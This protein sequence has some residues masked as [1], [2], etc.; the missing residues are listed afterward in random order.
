MTPPE[1]F[2]TDLLASMSLAEK[3]GQ[4]TQGRIASYSKADAQTGLIDGRWGSRILAETGW[5]G[6]NENDALDV[7]EMNEQQRLAVEESLTGIPLLFGRDVIYGHRTVFPIPH[8]QA[9]SFNPGLVEKACTC[10]AR[11]AT[12]D[13]VKWTFAPMLDLVRDPRWGRV[14]ESY[15]EDPHLISEMGC[16]TVRG[17]QGDDPSAPDRM[18]AC[19]KHFAGYGGSEGGRDYHVTDWSDDTLHNM[20]LP[21]FRAAVEAGCA[22]VMSGFNQLGGQS[23]SASPRLTRDWLKDSL[24]WDGFIVSDWGSIN[25]LI[26]HGQAADRR[27]AAKLALEAGID[28]DMVDGLYE[29]ELAALVEDGSIPESLIDDAV[30]R[31][32]RAKQRAGLFERP[33]TEPNPAVQR[34]PDHVA[35]AEELAAQ[36]AVL[37][38]NDGI[39]PLDSGLKTVAVLGPYAEA[40]RQHL[41]SWCLDGRPAEV[42]PI[43]DALRRELPEITFRTANPAFS[44]EMM[45]VARNT[46]LTILCVGESHVRNGE[47]KSIS[48]LALPPGQEELIESF[49]R[50]GLNLVVVDCSGRHLPSPAA[51]RYARALLHA[52]SLGT[53]AGTAIAR[54]LSGAVSPSGKLP[55]TVPRS[56]GQIPLYYNAK[57]PGSAVHR[58]HFKGYEEQ[59]TSPLYPFG[60]GLTYSTFVLENTTLLSETLHAGE[61]VTLRTELRNT[62]ERTAAQVVQLYVQAAAANP[63]R[64]A[65]ELKAFQRI[66][67]AP[68]DSQVLEFTIGEKQLG[69]YT[70][71]GKWILRPGRFRLAIG[72]DSTSDFT[73]EVCYT[74]SPRTAGD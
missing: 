71:Q 13:G 26:H 20:I 62:G 5:A 66:E 67:L 10:V 49:G 19:A 53:E 48:E 51:E 70:P 16:A 52:G 73:H 58:K 74:R 24:G 6:N 37:L 57:L 3:I 7:P 50:L 9:A 33:F 60:Y 61:T 8:S 54:L 31:I 36:C 69:A 59:L 4:L 41:G 15:G 27:E 47:A 11:E 65:R 30:L 25:D 64:P 43:L 38:Q 45:A 32:L 34:A 46:E 18:L 29:E 12:A 40:R 21:P 2:L 14:I 68:G 55:M 23:V 44:D 72:F 39:L 35:L 28:M 42:T 56:T 17:F 63:T 1:S 22:S